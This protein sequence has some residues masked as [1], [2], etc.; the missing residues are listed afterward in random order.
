MR[1]SFLVRPQKGFTNRLR[2]SL[3]ANSGPMPTHLLYEGPYGH[4]PSFQRFAN[5][6]LVIGGSGISVG[7]SHVYNILEQS[8]EARLR[9]VWTCRKT[10]SYMDSVMETELRSALGTGRLRIDA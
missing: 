10:Q 8:P 7:I 4:V 3:L 1:Y 6:L 2:R 9:L 5:A